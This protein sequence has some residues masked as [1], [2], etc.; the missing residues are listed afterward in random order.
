MI[1]YSIVTVPEVIVRLPMIDVYAAGIR[2]KPES[3]PPERV[4][5]N[6]LSELNNSVS[7]KSM[8]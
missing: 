4:I 3:Y 7:A 2:V 5:E 8:A 1:I 6:G